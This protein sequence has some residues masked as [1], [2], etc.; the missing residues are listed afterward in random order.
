MPPPLLLQRPDVG[1]CELL[2]PST[3]PADVSLSAEPPEVDEAA[4][5]S[6]V[7]ALSLNI[8]ELLR[9][10][11]SSE[12]S[13]ISFSMTFIPGGERY[14]VNQSFSKFISNSIYIT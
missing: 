10:S 9:L 2:S 1:G 3:P 6:Q 12:L 4:A 11:M 14:R 8:V 7:L 5:L 13:P